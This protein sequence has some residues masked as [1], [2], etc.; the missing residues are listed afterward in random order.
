MRSRGGG[1]KHGGSSCPE[2]PTVQRN[3]GTLQF[4]DEEWLWSLESTKS[5]SLM[6]IFLGIA[7]QCID[8]SCFRTH[9]GIDSNV[10]TL[11]HS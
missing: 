5:I 7:K 3:Y 6:I 10:G 9:L 2:D 4:T 8:V 1:V 11:Q